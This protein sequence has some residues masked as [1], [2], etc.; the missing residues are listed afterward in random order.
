MDELKVIG[1]DLWRDK[2]LLIAVLVGIAGLVYILIKRQNQTAP[3]Q[4][5]TPHP[6]SGAT[7]VENITY[8]QQPTTPTTPTTPTPGPPH[9]FPPVGGGPFPPPIPVQQPQPKTVTVTPW[10]T[11]Y[12]SL[13]DIAAAFYGSGSLWPK[14]YTA[15]KSVIGPDPNLIR[16]GQVLVIP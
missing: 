3:L 4:T 12:G 2:P 14:I 5:T 1:R 7:Y 13:W 10:G 15:N 8:A 11:K 6:A 9:I 16:P